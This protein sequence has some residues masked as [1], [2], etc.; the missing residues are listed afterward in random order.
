LDYQTSLNRVLGLTNYERLPGS[1]YTSVAFNLQRMSDLLKQLGNPHLKQPSVHVAGTKGKGSTS[2]MIASSLTTSGYRT[3][4][5]TS[6]HL[7]TIR[8]RIAINGDPITEDDFS[9]ALE[10]IWDVIE[11][12][13]T[14][15]PENPITTFE[16]LTALAFMYFSKK[17]VEFQVLEVG[18]GGRL[19]A[20]N[21]V[22][23]EVSVITSLSLDHTDILGD[24]LQKIAREKAGI[25]KSKVPLIT[26][27]QQPEALTVLEEVSENQSA[28][29]TLIGRDVTFKRTDFNSEMQEMQ[30]AGTIL[31]RPFEHHVRIPL[32][33]MHQ[34]ENAALAITTLECL[35]SK[36][37]PI[38]YDG[39]YHG[40][41]NV[42][43][44]GRLEQ[45]QD[46]PRIII[47]GAHNT[48]SAKKLREALDE[49][50]KYNSLHLIVGFS[51]DKDLTGMINEWAPLS[52]TVITTQSRHPR[53]VNP[54]NM[55]T[56]FEKFGIKAQ[57]M[58]NITLAL[59]EARDH[60]QENDI[61]L[62]TGSLFIISE[63]REIILG[64]E[65]ELYVQ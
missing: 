33:G 2:A 50:Y 40:M 44:P 64:I 47:D 16:A 37:Y 49:Y 45:L 29:I 3:G 34:L 56:E 24:T 48:W 61:I 31:D 27:N 13:N 30:I 12:I 35:R 41:A 65:P 32:L 53:S 60:A 18:L 7:H 17:G 11:T 25:I 21:I 5:F 10:G 26:A 39:I 22:K 9:S 59:Q 63:A 15:V 62:V 14:K 8:E 23:P 57:S 6:P 52:S 43:W 4:L 36:G 42:L 51:S 55:A 1:A 46:N 19:D 20:T 54:E 58:P 38:P 28:S